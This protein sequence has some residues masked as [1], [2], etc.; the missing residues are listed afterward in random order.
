M[1]CGYYFKLFVLE[2]DDKVGVFI[3]FKKELGDFS[4]NGFCIWSYNKFLEMRVGIV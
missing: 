4:R 3:S 1:V 2:G